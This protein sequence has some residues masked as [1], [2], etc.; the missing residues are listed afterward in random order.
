MAYLINKKLVI[1]IAS[2]ALFDLEESHAIFVAEGEEKYREHQK[3]NLDVVLQK[4][5]AFSFIKRFL[6]INK[7]HQED[8]PVEVILL[9]RNDPDTGQRVFNSIK[10]YG[11]DIT[12]AAFLSGKSPYKYIPAFNVSLFLSANAS[13]AKEAIK[14][15]YPAGTVIPSEFTD[16]ETDNELRVAFDF[17]GVIA[18]DE[19][20]TQY[21]RQENL[22]DFHDYEN[23]NVD[24]SHNPGPLSDFFKKL[25]AL[26]KM[27]I[28]KE[29]NENDYKRII[30]IAIITARG[31]PA[32][33]RVITTLNEWGVLP[34]ET[35]FLGGVEKN[36]IL[37]VLKPHIFFDDQMK[38]IDPVAK[39][40]PSVHIPFGIRNLEII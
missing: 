40:I 13:D 24:T 21:Q 32:H 3:K 25:S 2:S 30:R 7:N 8:M 28:K 17:D 29:R 18:D 10:H 4:G 9:S 36:N 23:K 38:H 27:E 16:A 31:A 33:Q 26:Q 20:E 19:A 6:G 34:D 35:F 22:D 12:R 14:A 11:L 39:N 5:V 15:G 37:Q 1:G